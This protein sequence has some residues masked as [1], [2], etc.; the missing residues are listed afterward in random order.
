MCTRFYIEVGEKELT[1]ILQA[2][3]D[4]L[5]AN[6]FNH[7]GY[8]VLTEGEIRPTDVVPV[9]A[10]SPHGERS[11]YPMKWGYTIP[12]HK[13]KLFNAR[14][15]TAAVKPAFRDDWRSHRCIIPA[16]YY[17]EWEHIRM[18]D[19]KTKPGR[20]YAIQP[21]DAGLT[22]LCGLYRI[23]NGLPVF[24]ILTR[25]PGDS[26]KHIHDRMPLILPPEK[27]DDW[28]D[29]GAKPEAVLPYALTRMAVEYA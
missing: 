1:D 2:A 8:P 26:V 24:V 29:P 3:K 28:I 17:F 6:K 25:Q 5:L 11:V 15:E 4:S 12:A 13:T 9:I 22:C 14:C 20:K 23:E 16:S 10:P 19:G 21:G 18:K 7:L 27:I